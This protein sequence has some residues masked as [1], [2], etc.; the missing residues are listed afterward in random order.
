VIGRQNLVHW[1][2][3]LS[4]SPAC[5]LLKGAAVSVPRF[6]PCFYFSL[7]YFSALFSY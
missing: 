5:S 3:P 2:P 6:F 7:L 4:F 1:A